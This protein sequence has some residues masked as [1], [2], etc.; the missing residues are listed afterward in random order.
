MSKKTKK[1]P[2]LIYDAIFK[3][4]KGAKGHEQIK[5]DRKLALEKTR[6]EKK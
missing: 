4:P 2:D 1:E 5:R 6:R 3:R